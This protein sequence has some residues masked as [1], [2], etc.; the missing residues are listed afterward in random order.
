MR[1]KDFK[2]YA[3]ECVAQD[4]IDHL[5]EEHNF[6]VKSV[7]EDGLKGKLDDI[8]VQR[9]NK[10]RRFL[11]TY[12]KKD[13]FT[14]DKLAPFKGLTGIICLTFHKSEYPCGHLQRLYGHDK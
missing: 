4:F 6:N 2:L 11:L 5:R 7:I 3:D 13:F 14:N 8:I 1:L 12:D 10:M 9:A